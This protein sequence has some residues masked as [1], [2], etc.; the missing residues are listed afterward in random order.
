MIVRDVFGP[1][2][3]TYNGLIIQTN[4]PTLASSGSIKLAVSKTGSF[5]ANLTLAGAKTAFKASLIRPATRATPV[6][7]ATV[8]V[9]LGCGRRQRRLP[10]Q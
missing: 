9:A 10:A 1:L 8:M 7:D 3:G 5:A 4:A 6:A 2:A